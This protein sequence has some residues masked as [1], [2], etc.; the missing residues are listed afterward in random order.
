MVSLTGEYMADIKLNIWLCKNPGLENI[1]LQIYQL[2]KIDGTIKGDSDVQGVADTISRSHK[3]KVLASSI[4]GF[5]YPAVA[6]ISSSPLPRTFYETN[7]SEYQFTLMNA[8]QKIDFRMESH[9]RVIGNIISLAVQTQIKPLLGEKLWQRSLRSR[10]YCELTPESIEYKMTTGDSKRYNL[11]RGFSYRVDIFPNGWVGISADIHSTVLDASS[12][13]ERLKATGFKA[14]SEEW[15]NQYSTVVDKKGQYK[16]RFIRDI[17]PD[18]TISTY[19][20]KNKLGG[21]VSVFD[22]Y[23][24]KHPLTGNELRPDDS[25][26]KIT[27][28]EGGTDDYYVPA[29]CI[30]DI[31]S[32]DELDDDK[33]ISRRL[34]ISPDNRIKKIDFYRKNYLKLDQLSIPG[35]VM[36]FSNI[37]AGPED[38]TSGKIELPSLRFDRGN[39]NP[40]DLPNI[41]QWRNAKVDSLRK[42]GWFRHSNLQEILIIHP[43]MR[44]EELDEFYSDLRTQAKQWDEDLPDSPTYL[45]TANYNDIQRN[46]DQFQE[47][48]GAAIV[49]FK[50]RDEEIYRRMKQS[51]KIPSQGV[52]LSS[53]RSKSYLVRSGK[54]QRYEDMLLNIL[55]GLLGKNGA[56]PWVM[57]NPLSCDCFIGVDSG[58]AESRIWS[59]AYL[60]DTRGEYVGSKCG[61]PIKGESIE[62]GRF[63]NSILEALG[64]Y[65]GC[66][67]RSPRKII[68]HRDGR[69]TYSE[70]EGLIEAIH[71]MIDDDQLSGDVTVAAVD[72]KKSHSF[73]IFERNDG[74]YRNPFIG[75][76]F[77][78]DDTRCIINT[79]GSPALPLQVTAHPLLLD[80]DPIIGQFNI[81]DVAKDVFYLS[82]LNWGSPKMNIKMPITIRFAEKRIE[83]ADK[84]IEFAD[85]IPI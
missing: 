7:E 71:S 54:Q 39:L 68:I 52:I 33:E 81:L 34:T 78:L 80:I 65:T 38:F 8:N 19:K 58:G 18:V 2:K 42:Y 70:R 50:G 41:G 46:L 83:Y 14:F 59:Y 25:V 31:L 20:V 49:I 28:Y 69:L 60:F 15:K 13:A 72:I 62:K 53:I 16:V 77:L 11:F 6:I 75:S 27:Y 76:Y 3:G 43:M 61:Q 74:T 48:F 64:Q 24:G 30:Y 56:I 32:T 29:S 35:A 5:D 67:R 1:P 10:R 40:G 37:L 82:E 79:T 45:P 17:I 4:G 9:R 66:L 22:S 44:K 12:M 47:R 51:L 36:N 23:N 63:K 55:S 73:R 57:L 26:I 21:E 85:Q 84:S